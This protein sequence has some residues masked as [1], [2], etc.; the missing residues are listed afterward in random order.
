MKTTKNAQFKQDYM[1][2][3]LKRDSM[4]HRS[5]G[6][7]FESMP[8]GAAQIAVNEASSF[9]NEFGLTVR[10]TGIRTTT[11]AAGYGIVLDNHMFS[12]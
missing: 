6:A 9:N 5:G 8:A 4:T 2:D 10:P 11:K 3:N 7:T 12:N 1:L